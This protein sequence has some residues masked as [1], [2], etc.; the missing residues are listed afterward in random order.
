MTI[1]DVVR[2]AQVWQSCDPMP[3]AGTRRE[4]HEYTYAITMLEAERVAAHAVL[5]EFEVAPGPLCRRIIALAMRN[6]Q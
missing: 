3:D 2:R 6:A 5:D 4:T 1:P